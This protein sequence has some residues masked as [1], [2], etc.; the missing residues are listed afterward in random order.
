MKSKIEIEMKSTKRLKIT[1]K[2]DFLKL[3]CFMIFFHI[4]K[5]Y[6]NMYR[7]LRVIK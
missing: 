4:I 5:K 2:R 3:I 6:K 7:N 1:F